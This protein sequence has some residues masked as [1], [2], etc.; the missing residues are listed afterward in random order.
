MACRS[1]GCECRKF[2]P[3][4][5]IKSGGCI[6]CGHSTNDHGIMEDSI[7]RPH[8]VKLSTTT[9][10]L[11]P[12]NQTLGC[13]ADVS[14]SAKLSPATTDA[15]PSKTVAQKAIGTQPRSL[16]RSSTYVSPGAIK[17][18]VTDVA[19]DQLME[20][21]Q[22]VPE[23]TRFKIR[24]D[25]IAR[26]IFMTE[27]SYVKSMLYVVDHDDQNYKERT[28]KKNKKKEITSCLL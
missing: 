1:G 22:Y 8:A 16:T 24:R 13:I 25:L 6:E 7:A 17:K 10:Q 20:A 4:Q 2:K 18:L 5:F 21:L 9:Q 19:E 12:R 27:Q 26:E 15:N 23:E 28:R 14:R 3:H 11:Y